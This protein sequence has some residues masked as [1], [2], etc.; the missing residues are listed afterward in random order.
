MAAWS[1][2]FLAAETGW[3]RARPRRCS[4]LAFPDHPLARAQRNASSLRTRIAERSDVAALVEVVPPRPP[5]RNAQL[6]RAAGEDVGDRARLAGAHR[7]RPLL[8]DAR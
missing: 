2:S 7:G 3:A 1:L 4:V 6:L 8:Q 5:E